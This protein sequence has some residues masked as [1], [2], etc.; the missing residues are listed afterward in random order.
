MRDRAI[1]I[2]TTLVALGVAK[3]HLCTLMLCSLTVMACDDQTTNTTS[4]EGG[5]A[6]VA[7]MNHGGVHAGMMMSIG[8][9]EA[10]NTANLSCTQDADCP[11][12]TLCDSTSMS[13]Q[14]GCLTSQECSQNE[15]CLEGLCRQ[16]DPCSEDQPCPQNAVCSCDGL[17]FP[18]VGAPCTGNLQCAPTTE[19]C[20]PCEGQCK[21]RIEPCGPCLLSESCSRRGDLCASIGTDTQKTCLRRCEGQ[22]TCDQVGPGYVCQALGSTP[23][24]YCIPESGNCAS[25]AQCQSDAACPADHFCNE[26]QQCQIGCLGEDTSCPMG[27]LCQGLRCAPPCMT[28]NDCGLDSAICE[29][30]RCKI[31]GGCTSSQDCLEAETYCNLDRNRCV[32]GCQVDN[33]CLD[34]TKEC[35]GGRCRPRGCSRNYQCSFGEVCDLESNQCVL[36][37]GRHCEMGCD[38]QASDSSCGSEGQRCLS[39]QDEE[40]NPIGDF[41]FEPCQ[42]EP[43]PCPQGYSCT[44]L[45]DPN[46]GELQLC[47]RR[48]DVA[49]I[50]N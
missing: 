4:G 29:E 24:M 45:E 50:G 9:S 5:S 11:P 17:C 43:N 20:D 6:Q 46:V 44:T 32:S 19:Y 8:G 40:E 41:C 30:G 3:G 28:A 42:P 35:V 12:G 49:P 36:A 27:Q 7:G 15:R 22:A 25:V 1:H 39:L 10:G 26:R 37:E 13:C 47:I 34:A 2:L 33:D 21:P 18:K 14:V 38:P 16:L 23:D 48:C 31:P